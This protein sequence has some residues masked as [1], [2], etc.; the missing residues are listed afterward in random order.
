MEHIVKR[1]AEMKGDSPTEDK[2]KQTSETE[3]INDDD[4]RK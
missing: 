2:R 1:N 4:D 3:Q